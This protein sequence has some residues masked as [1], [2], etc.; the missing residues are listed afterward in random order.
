MNSRLYSVIPS[1]F[2]FKCPTCGQGEIG[3]K[4]IGGSVFRPKY[5]CNH[6][7]KLASLRNPWALPALIGVGI[8]LTAPML[9]VAA[10]SVIPNTFGWWVTGLGLLIAYV[11]VLWTAMPALTRALCSWKSA[12]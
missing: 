12:E 2:Y 6:C 9:A 11:L 3:P 7:S 5:K 10:R 1:R 8:G 4:E